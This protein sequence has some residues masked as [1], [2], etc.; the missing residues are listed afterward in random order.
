MLLYL[1]MNSRRK[2]VIRSIAIISLI[3]V[4]VGLASFFLIQQTFFPGMEEHDVIWKGVNMT[5]YADEFFTNTYYTGSYLNLWVTVD[6]VQYSVGDSL[7]IS[8]S[9]SVGDGYSGGSSHQAGFITHNLDLR[10]VMDTETLYYISFAAGGHASGSSSSFAEFYITDGSKKA[11]LYAGSA[12]DKMSWGKSNIEIDRALLIGLDRGKPWNLGLD[13]S[14]GNPHNVN[15]KSDGSSASFTLKS[16]PDMFYIPCDNQCSAVG[17]KQC[18]ESGVQTCVEDANKCL[19]WSTIQCSPSEVCS[20]GTCSAKEVLPTEQPIVILETP[21]DETSAQT[22]SSQTGTNA[23]PTQTDNSKQPISEQK[24]SPISLIPTLIGFGALILIL[25]AGL[26]VFFRF[27]KK[28][29]K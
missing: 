17:E 28:K 12:N 23:Q 25:I 26:I 14:I 7:S 4:L 16:V 8:I 24:E 21:S 2:K 20:N 29:R 6:D 3:V 19:S 18:N 27:R 1:C 15:V 5:V 13:M 10:K 11:R 22:P 9:N